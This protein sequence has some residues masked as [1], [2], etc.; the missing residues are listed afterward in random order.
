MKSEKFY[1]LYDWQ[2]DGFKAGIADSNFR[3]V[4]EMGAARAW[5]L[6]QS[7]EEPCPNGLTDKEI[8]ES[9]DY[10]VQEVAEEVYKKIMRNNEYGLFTVVSL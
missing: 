3:S 2:L 6:S 4:E 7:D 1:A 8:L 10:E 5:D 9:Y